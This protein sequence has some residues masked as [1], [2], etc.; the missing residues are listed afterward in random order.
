MHTAPLRHEPAWV[1]LAYLT[2]G[3]GVNEMII[4]PDAGVIVVLPLQVNIKVGQVIAL[5]H[6]ELLSH[7]VTFL[8][9]TLD[10]SQKIQFSSHKHAQ[11]YKIYIKIYKTPHI[12]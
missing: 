6:R 2:H 7:L 8:L 4:T 11:L 1:R 3:F 5:R 12:L 9:T 10:K